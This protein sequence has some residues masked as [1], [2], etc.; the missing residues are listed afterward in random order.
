MK[1]LLIEDDEE[2]AAFIKRGLL[3]Q[4]FSIGH[5]TTSRGGLHKIRYRL[6]IFKI[7]SLYVGIFTE[8]PNVISQ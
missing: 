1:V 3:K 2:I 8:T 7:S 5:A 6:D 4:G